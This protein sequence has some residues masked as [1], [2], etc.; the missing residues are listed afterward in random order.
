MVA[1]PFTSFPRKFFSKEGAPSAVPFG[2]SLTSSINDVR[3]DDCDAMTSCA[4][5]LRIAADDS[6]QK[7]SATSIAFQGGLLVVRVTPA[8]DI[9]TMQ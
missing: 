3:D 8:L 2:F 4:S 5:W 1:L 6:T 7:P 9:V